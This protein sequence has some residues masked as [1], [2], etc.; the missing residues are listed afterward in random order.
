MNEE[1][2]VKKC[3]A[4]DRHYQEIFYRKFADKMYNI[5]LSYTGN[6]DEAAD[7][8]QDG[9]MKIFR[10][11][12]QFNFEGSLEGWVRKIIVNTA[13]ETIRKKIKEQEKV[14]KINESKENNYDLNLSDLE[15]QKIIELVNLLPVKAQ[16]VLKLYAIEGFSHKEIAHNLNISE[17]TS[18]SQLNRARMLL[19]QALLK[20][21]GS[22]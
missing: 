2:L 18:K 16:L 7:I 6:H 13:L 17:G 14:I 10:K 1:L 4:F 21:N 5:C 19:K 8:L 3:I 9:F 15:G 12:K 22:I 11:I 20:L